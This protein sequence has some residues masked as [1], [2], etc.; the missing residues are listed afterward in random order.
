[1]SGTAQP[2]G[3]TRGAH[4]LLVDDDKDLVTA[5]R[6]VLENAGYRVSAAYHADAGFET[7]QAE[8]PDLLIFDV[9]MPGATEGFHL[10][11][12]IRRLEEAYFRQVPIMVV[13]AI[14][15]RT[16]FR[17]DDES[18]DGTYSAGEFLPVQEFL[19]KPV[20]PAVLLDRIARL[21]ARSG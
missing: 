8:R 19:D 15:E 10:V 16:A 4:I 2:D 14:H 18:P 5:M 1:M 20:D 12:R 7:I 9:M 13:S 11:W 21:L 3:R 17:F 6:L